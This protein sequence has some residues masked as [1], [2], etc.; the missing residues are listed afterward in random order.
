MLDEKRNPRGRYTLTELLK[1]FEDPEVKKAWD[2]YCESDEFKEW[3]NMKPV[4]AE[5]GADDNDNQKP[6]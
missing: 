4:G 3:E 6:W 2:E 1:G 5:Y